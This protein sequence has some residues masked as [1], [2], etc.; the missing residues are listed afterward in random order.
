MWTQITLRRTV[1]VIDSTLSENKS[2]PDE[3]CL[4]YV[5][6]QTS[7]QTS[8]VIYLKQVSKRKI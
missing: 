4:S 5:C 6:G 1:P 2:Q 8:L 3:Q 7:R